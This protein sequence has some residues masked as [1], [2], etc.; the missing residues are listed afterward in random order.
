MWRWRQALRS[1]VAGDRDAHRKGLSAKSTP[2][3]RLTARRRFG[4]RRGTEGLRP[5]QRSVVLVAIFAVVV[6]VV[7]VAGLRVTQGSAP[8]PL[9]TSTVVPTATPTSSPSATPLPSDTPIPTS[10]PSATSTARP[11]NTA[12]P[13]K[14]ATPKPPTPTRTPHPTKTPHPATPTLVATS[15]PTIAPAVKPSATPSTTPTVVDLSI[16]RDSASNGGSTLIPPTDVW[17]TVDAASGGIRLVHVNAHSIAGFGCHADLGRSQYDSALLANQYTFVSSKDGVVI[18]DLP[19]PSSVGPGTYWANVR[20]GYQPFSGVGAPAQAV[21]HASFVL[22]APQDITPPPS[23]QV[24]TNPGKVEL[25]TA[26]S[27]YAKTEPNAVCS[28]Y[29]QQITGIIPLHTYRAGPSGLVQW[30]VTVEGGGTG[31]VICDAHKAYA[32]AQ[33]DF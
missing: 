17:A 25:R 15:T 7:L 1:W 23:L 16:A 8:P 13:T 6:G 19:I 20:C 12:R 33:S 9:P 26:L 5:M 31:F 18:L 30:H 27:L 24:W 3:T 22:P 4:P 14:T 2:Y 21:Y 11:T 28:A 32:R 29:V 10:T